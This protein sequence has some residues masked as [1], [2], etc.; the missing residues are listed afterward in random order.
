MSEQMLKVEQLRQLIATQG[1][2][3]PWLIQAAGHLGL[4]V[5][6]LQLPEWFQTAWNKRWGKIDL[7]NDEERKG[8]IWTRTDNQQPIVDIS[9]APLNVQ[10]I[11]FALLAEL[12]DAL[13][14]VEQL[15]YAKVGFPENW[16]R[17]KIIFNGKE[18]KDVV[19]ADALLG[20]CSFHA[21]DDKGKLI[22]VA[23]EIQTTTARGM[24]QILVEKNSQMFF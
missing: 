24:V 19:E 4:I 15:S 11:K 1:H 8:L 10:A 18:I 7:S 23:G 14:K 20:M 6:T 9:E 16:R 3:M 17:C 22:V 2:D 5:E 12:V 13:P 21:R